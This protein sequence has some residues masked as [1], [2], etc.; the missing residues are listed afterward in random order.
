MK[1]E[2]II[3]GLLI[4]SS[5][6]FGKV[7]FT[8][9]QNTSIDEQSKV[10]LT[11]EAISPRL[12]ILEKKPAFGTRIS[13]VSNELQTDS[14]SI[15]QIEDDYDY[16]PETIPPFIEKAMTWLAEAQHEDGTWEQG[17]VQG[18]K[19]GTLM[20][21]REIRQPLH[22]QQWHFLDQDTLPKKVNTDRWLKKRRKLWL[23]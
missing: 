23:R 8:P 12:K 14:H 2:K 19:S 20:R 10:L 15:D 9:S 11:E 16:K 3:S 17:Q 5:C 13:V 6:C 18:N 7:S 1:K 4:C 21:C 22:L